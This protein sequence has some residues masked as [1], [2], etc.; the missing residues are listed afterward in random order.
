MTVSP[1]FSRLVPLT[2]ALL[3]PGSISMLSMWNSNS[4]VRMPPMR[5]P[6]CSNICMLALKAS[7]C[8]SWLSV[9]RCV[10]PFITVSSWMMALLLSCLHI[11]SA[12]RL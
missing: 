12:S 1:I 4:T 2:L 8:W 7:H 10:W 11:S 9:A 3:R 6:I 5:S